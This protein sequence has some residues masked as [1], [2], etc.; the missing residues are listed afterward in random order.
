MIIELE[1]S[2]QNESTAYPW[3]MIIDP[4]QNFKTNNEGIHSIAHMIT[5]PFFS[6]A[7]AEAELKVR[8]YA[9]GKNAKVF[10]DS[11]YNTIAYRNA[12]R[13]GKK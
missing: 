12:I 10:C 6:R 2:E 7:E 1:I 9:Y 5:G 3:W 4:Q 13:K 11:G 8:R